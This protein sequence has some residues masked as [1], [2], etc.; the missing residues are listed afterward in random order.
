MLN[1]IKKARL[2]KGIRQKEFAEMLGISQ[3]S[4]CKWESGKA[5]PDVK[6]LKQVAQILDTTVDKLLPDNEEVS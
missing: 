6:R 3:V 1:N 2:I 5:M 4:V